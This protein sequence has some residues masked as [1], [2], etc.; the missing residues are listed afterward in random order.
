MKKIKSKYRNN[1]F[2][3]NDRKETYSYSLMEW[4][5]YREELDEADKVEMIK[6][7]DDLCFKSVYTPDY[8]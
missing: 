7:I 2:G 8:D 5:K 4:S 6:I 1:P 3:K